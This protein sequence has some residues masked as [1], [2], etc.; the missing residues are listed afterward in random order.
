[1]QGL[2]KQRRL[3]VDYP[4]GRSNREGPWGSSRVSIDI[5]ISKCGIDAPIIL[6]VVYVA[7][8]G[9]RNTNKS[10]KSKND[11]NDDQLYVLTT[12]SQWSG[13]MKYIPDVLLLAA[14]VSSEVGNVD[15]ECS[16]GTKRTVKCTQPR[17]C[18]LGSTKASLLLK[19][20]AAACCGKG[21]SKHSEEGR[22]DNDGLG[23]EQPPKSLWRYEEKWELEEPE[24]KIAK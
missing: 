4:S 15:G 5:V 3:L 24:D 14:G 18:Q 2:L 12:T 23:Q 19:D 1:M 21:P 20:G 16:N 13:V 8:G 11:G 7:G 10:H 17:P 9:A 6:P 22:G